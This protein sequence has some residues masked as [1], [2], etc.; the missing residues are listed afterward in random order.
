MSIQQSESV[1]QRVIVSVKPKGNIQCEKLR[2]NESVVSH[3][4]I[5]GKR[6][7]YDKMVVMSNSGKCLP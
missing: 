2:N 6:P 5:L 1:Y 3:L 7:S 4:Q